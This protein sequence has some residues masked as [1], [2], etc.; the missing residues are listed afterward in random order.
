VN[1]LHGALAASLA[2]AG[3][4]PVPGLTLAMVT[5]TDKLPFADK[6]QDTALGALGLIAPPVAEVDFR[7]GVGCTS[8][9]RKNLNNKHSK[10][11]DVHDDKVHFL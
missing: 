9:E 7:P 8:V 2:Q 3:E 4:H 5:L 10:C 6:T 1:G 11:E